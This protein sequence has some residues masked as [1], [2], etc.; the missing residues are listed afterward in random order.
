MTRQFGAL[1]ALVCLLDGTALTQEQSNR[2]RKAVEILAQSARAIGAAPADM[3]AIG[4]VELTEGSAVDSGSITITSLGLSKTSER[5]AVRGDDR[6]A[7]FADGLA[8]EKLNGN[9]RKMSFGEGL[10]SQSASLPILLIASTLADGDFA[11][12]YLGTENLEG[13]EA[14][15]LKF[16][17]T[18]SSR[19]SFAPFAEL[20]TRDL[21]IEV[22]TGL[23]IKLWYEQ[24]AGWGTS[25]RIAVEA[26]YSDFRRVGSNLLPFR[27]ERN[28]NGT[29]WADIRI[30]SY[31][32]N[33]GISKAEFQVEARVR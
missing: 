20:T 27:I 13:V 7:I 1:C 31:E 3:K 18:F 25:A 15:H 2:D 29:P 30:S 28:L 8:D 32:L 6:T 9:G 11:V 16:W 23:P 22:S 10:N 26:R 5:M 12:K 24:R 19:K 21:W 14:H 4:T 33:S 17:N